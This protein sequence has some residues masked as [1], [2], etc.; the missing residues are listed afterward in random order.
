MERSY[1]AVFA[2]LSPET[3]RRQASWHSWMI[4]V[5][6]FLFLAS[7][8]NANAFSGFPSANNKPFSE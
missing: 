1:D 7:P 6:Y 2:G 4:S 5:A 8:E 3:R